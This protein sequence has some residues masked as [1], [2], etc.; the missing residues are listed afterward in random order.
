MRNS[1]VF[2]LSVERRRKLATLDDRLMR[3]IANI[4]AGCVTEA[5]AVFDEFEKKYASLGA[6]RK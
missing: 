5:E 4:E 1:D 6:A 2:A 3:G